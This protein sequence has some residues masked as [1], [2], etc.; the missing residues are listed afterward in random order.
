MIGIV[1]V[2]GTLLMTAGQF[3]LSVGSI[4]AFTSVVMAYMALHHGIGVSVV[5]AV[6]AGL[7]VGVING[8]LVTVVEVNALITTLGTLA[9][10]RGLAEVVAD[11]QIG[12]ASTNFD[13]LGTARPFFN[14]PVPVILLVL[15]L[16]VVWP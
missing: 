13:S 8:F 14:I 15:V 16:V 2:P 6:G 1:A 7:V 4:V 10:F 11:G 9:A 12:A 3:D 5:V